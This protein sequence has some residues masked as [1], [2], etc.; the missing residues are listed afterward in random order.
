M[1]ASL[2]SET[3]VKGIVCTL[4]F[5]ILLPGCDSKGPG[6]KPT[7]GL[8]GLVRL[9]RQSDHS[10]ILLRIAGLDSI[11]VTDSTGSFSFSG[12]PDGRWRI[13]AR[14]PYFETGAVEAELACMPV[15]IVVLR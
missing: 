14:Y 1:K 9:Q 11:A 6:F 3:L 7:P 15:R 2:G 10:G 8:S 13:E 12:I 4:L 5:L